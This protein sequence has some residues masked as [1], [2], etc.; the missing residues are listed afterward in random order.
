[1]RE[2]NITEQT[3]DRWRR[4]YGDMGVSEAKKLKHL[5]RENAGLKRMVAEQVRMAAVLHGDVGATVDV[6][7]VPD[8]TD[9]SLEALASALCELDAGIHVTPSQITCGQ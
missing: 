9:H 4:K 2:H 3:F 5:E 6:D 1:V 7:V 8:R